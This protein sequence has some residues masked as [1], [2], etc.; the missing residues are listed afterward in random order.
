M[1][2]KVL[3]RLRSDCQR[4]DNTLRSQKLGKA[5]IN[6]KDLYALTKLVKDS[7]EI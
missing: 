1:G 4:A 2:Q 7:L 5:I 6:D 3:V